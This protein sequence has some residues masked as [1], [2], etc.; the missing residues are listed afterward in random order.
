MTD[1]PNKMTPRFPKFP[2]LFKNSLVNLRDVGKLMNQY[3]EEESL[4]SQPQEN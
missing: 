4:M 1:F 3:S 2:P